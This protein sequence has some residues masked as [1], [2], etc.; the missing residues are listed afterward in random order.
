MTFV[1]QVMRGEIHWS[2]Q[3]LLSRRHL[4]RDW[5]EA[6]TVTFLSPLYIYP[7]N[8]ANSYFQ[9]EITCKQPSQTIQIT[10]NN[11]KQKK[12]LRHWLRA[13]LKQPLLLMH[14]LPIDRPRIAF[15]TDFRLFQGIHSIFKSCLVVYSSLPYLELPLSTILIISQSTTGKRRMR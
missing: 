13:C 5:G 10:L 4:S 7:N 11:S 15:R 3:P 1:W 12:K 8:A 6:S 9:Q 2:R 14:R